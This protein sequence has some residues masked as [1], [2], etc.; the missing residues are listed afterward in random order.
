MH[1]AFINQEEP[2]KFSKTSFSEP[3]TESYLVKRE[4]KKRR[5]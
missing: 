4:R 3:V 5:D 1:Q 2:I